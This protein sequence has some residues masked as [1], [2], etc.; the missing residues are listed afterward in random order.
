MSGMEIVIQVNKRGN[1]IA[2][3]DELLP[4]G[5]ATG[6]APRQAFIQLLKQVVHYYEQHGRPL[7]TAVRVLPLRKRVINISATSDTA[8]SQFGALP[9]GEPRP[10]EIVVSRSSAAYKGYSPDNRRYPY[11]ERRWQALTAAFDRVYGN[12][13][14][15]PKEGDGSQDVWETWNGQDEA[16]DGYIVMD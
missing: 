13:R 11:T 12:G 4:L 5:H 8:L 7:P 15:V 6:N 14:P 2:K 16:V 1:W 9:P 10:M 3:C